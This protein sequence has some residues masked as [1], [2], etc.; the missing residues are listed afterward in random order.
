L[1]QGSSPSAQSHFEISAANR[2]EEAGRAAFHAMRL[3]STA[4]TAIHSFAQS[5]CA[6]FIDAAN[7]SFYLAPQI[8]PEG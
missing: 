1:G 3:F 5:S 7:E 8:E 2:V 4:F 6:N